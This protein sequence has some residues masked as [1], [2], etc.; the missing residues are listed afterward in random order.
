M[1]L[2]DLR[3]RSPLSSALFTKPK[4]AEELKGLVHGYT[5]IP[6][7]GAMPFYQRPLFWGIVVG[8]LFAILQW[9]FW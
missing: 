8:V 9:I 1:V 4:T 7:E 5:D 2:L 3:A 6:S